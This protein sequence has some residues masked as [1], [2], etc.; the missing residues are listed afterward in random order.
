MDEEVILKLWDALEFSLSPDNELRRDAEKFVYDSMEMNGFWSAMLHIATHPQYKEGRRIDVTQAAAIQFKNMAEIHWRFKNETHA[1]DVVVEGFRFIIIQNEDKEYIRT[2]IMSMLLE[3]TNPSVRSQLTYAV[4]WIVRID[5]PEK[6]PNLIVEVKSFIDTNEES[7]IVTGLEALKSICK[8]YEFEYGKGRG[9]LEDIVENIFPR[10]EE[11]VSQIDDNSTIEAFDTKWR[12][13]DL[14]YTVNQ[15]NIC[16]RYKNLE[17]L[18]K[19]VN[20]YKYALDCPIG[21]DL[22]D[23]TEDTDTISHRRSR[24]EWKFK[25]VAIRFVLSCT[26]PPTRG[27]GGTGS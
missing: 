2:N 7:K 3:V 22:V 9:P 27:W 13:A 23:K 17:G 15:V 21:D 25:V 11:I 24:P 10:L 19:L 12:I 14:L 16:S 1:R 6:W 4:E 8:R 26:P 20:F 5:F 18:D